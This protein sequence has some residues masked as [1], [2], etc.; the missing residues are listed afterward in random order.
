MGSKL[1]PILWMPM[2]AACPVA[3][4]AVFNCESRRHFEVAENDAGFIVSR[5]CA[6][7]E[8]LRRQE[9]KQQG[10]ADVLEM[11]NYR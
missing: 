8:S 7:H 4:C 3:F 5:F 10:G 6:V 1:D 9:C 11:E 2:Y